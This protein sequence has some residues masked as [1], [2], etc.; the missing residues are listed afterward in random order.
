MF[1]F[2]QTKKHAINHKQNIKYGELFRCFS[3]STQQQY[4]CICLQSCTKYHP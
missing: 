4:T 1:T 2:I 3:P